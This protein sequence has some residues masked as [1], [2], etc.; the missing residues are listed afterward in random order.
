MK[1]FFFNKKKKKISVFIEEGDN[2]RMFL[3]K[4]YIFSKLA[5]ESQLGQLN[6]H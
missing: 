2:K 4:K 3:E 5:N 6:F 1:L